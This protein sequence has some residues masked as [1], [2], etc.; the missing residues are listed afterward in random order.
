MNKNTLTKTQ[1]IIIKTVND[2]KNVF[3]SGPGGSGKSYVI[4]EICELARSKNLNIIVTATTGCAAVLLGNNAKTLNSWSGIGLADKPLSDILSNIMKNK[5][6]C[7]R[8]RDVD[9]LVI[10]EVSMLS[11]HLFDILNEIGK[12]TRKS[13]L[14]FGGIQLVFSG[15]FYQLPP[16]GNDGCLKSKGFCFESEYW[17]STFGDNQ[18]CL[19]KV[20]RQ[21]GDNEYKNILHQIR[22]GELTEETCEILKNCVGKKNSSDITPVKLYPRKNSVDKINNE[23]NMK[24]LGDSYEYTIKTSEILSKKTSTGEKIRN[25]LANKEIIDRVLKCASSATNDKL[26]LKI[27][28]QVMCVVNLDMINEKQICNGSCG[29]V[30][31]FNSTKLPIVRYHNGREELMTN[32]VRIISFDNGKNYE[33]SMMPL[34]LCWAMSIHKSQGC[35]LDIAEIDIGSDIFECGQSYVALSRVRSLKGL[36]LNSFDASKIKIKTKVKRFYEVLSST[37][38]ANKITEP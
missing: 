3:I 29:K 19:K 7:S 15:D 28:S 6:I 24:L 1:N 18:L 37:A 21:D 22:K 38:K 11:H 34:I 17:W 31:G 33:I 23:Y 10:D 13:V 5:Y 12:Y 8:W 36:F 14:P 27:G 25:P 20:F 16:I 30:I 4:N 9:V 32:Y 2:G 35:S 26:I